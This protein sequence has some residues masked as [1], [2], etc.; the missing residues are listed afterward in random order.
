[1]FERLLSHVLS[2][3]GLI[4]CAAAQLTLFLIDLGGLVCRW[5]SFERIRH[6]DFKTVIVTLGV[7]GTFVGVLNA[8]YGFNTADINASVPA[9]LEGLKFAFVASVLG[10]GLS[11]TLSIL[12]KFGGHTDDETELFISMEQ[13]MAS[14][15]KKIGSL[16]ATL[17]SP[18]VLVKQFGEMKTFLQTELLQ[19]NKSLDK[20]LVQLATGATQEVIQ[21]LKN[22]IMEFNTN[23]QEQFGDNFKE[24]NQA[25][26][27]LVEWQRNYKVHIDGLEKHI[28]QIMDA[29]EESADSARDIV[30][31]NKEVA[32]V[33]REVSGLIRTYD[34]QIK[35]LATYL[36]SCKK[37]GDE[38][39]EFLTTTEHAFKQSAQN[40]TSFSD[41]IENSV[42][43]QSE[44]LAVLTKEIENQVPKA[45]GE[46]EDVLTKL[47]NQFASD[48]RSLF[49]FITD[50]R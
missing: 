48:Y 49:E 15:D 50:K 35:T 2:D 3:T 33:C 38:A 4:A 21:A 47:T 34:F 14:V 22:V 12:E 1:M 45:L 37:L 8:L 10:M 30:S 39:K 42:S 32:E 9:L 23:L 17:E 5:L 36:E 41:A 31:R 25:C 46:L 18:T 13:K 16:V 7:F 40:M 44:S 28:K 6:I 26:L 20:A 19:I 11:V 29:M 43:K 24:L 27:K